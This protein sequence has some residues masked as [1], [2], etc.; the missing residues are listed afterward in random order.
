ML[1]KSI[2]DS[3][4]LT[5]TILL[6]IVKISWK[7]FSIDNILQVKDREYTEKGFCKIIMKKYEII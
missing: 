7:N 6:E 3:T 5:T 1:D 4:R 2:V